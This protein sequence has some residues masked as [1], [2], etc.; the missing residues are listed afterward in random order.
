M[1]EPCVQSTPSA[2]DSL[3]VL[4]VAR[5]LVAARQK[6]RQNIWPSLSSAGS[7]AVLALF[8][9][10]LG[11]EVPFNEAGYGLED[12][13]RRS[14]FCYDN[15]GRHCYGVSFGDDSLSVEILCELLLAPLWRAIWR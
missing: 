14:D 8:W 5:E 15:S 1:L 7:R 6:E 10:T 3:V 2:S 12:W 13:Q 11:Q 9:P 4:C